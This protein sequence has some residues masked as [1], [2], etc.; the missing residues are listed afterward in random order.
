MDPS[1]KDPNR[2]NN[3]ACQAP[4]KPHNPLTGKPSGYIAHESSVLLG[5]AMKGKKSRKYY[6]YTEYFLTTSSLY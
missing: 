3:Q 2:E 6:K 1:G 4:I 5:N